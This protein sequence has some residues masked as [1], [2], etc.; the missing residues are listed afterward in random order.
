[1]T[2]TVMRTY[3]E[4]DSDEFER[5]T[6]MSQLEDKAKAIKNKEIE[7]KWAKLE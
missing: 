4:L 7:N 3:M 2:Y 5:L 1:M 6:A